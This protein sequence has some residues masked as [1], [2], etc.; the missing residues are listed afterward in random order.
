[1]TRNLHT[2][3]LK[4][5][6]GYAAETSG[7]GQFHDFDGNAVIYNGAPDSLFNWVICKD[8]IT[9]CQVIKI[10]QFL[11][12]RNWEVT[13]AVDT[14]MPGLKFFL[15]K[16]GAKL[17]SEP[18]KAFLNLAGFYVQCSD[19]DNSLE[20]LKVE[21][22]QRLEMFDQFTSKIFCHK[23][24]VVTKFLKG[25]THIKQNS[26]N[27]F[28]VKKNQEFVGT[29][30]L[31]VQGDIAGFYADGVFE[32]YRNQG[33][34]TQLVLKRIQIAK[35]MGCQSVIAPCMSASVSLYKRIGFRMMGKLPLYIS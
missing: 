33:I 1:M 3:N 21:D 6:I 2:K 27:A 29:C 28:L 35:E 24:D 22:S 11:K 4:D 13:W 19:I 7:L 10:L 17:V 30:T 8:D 23:T 9:E 14:H 31:Y 15:E 32:K 16:H 26:L 12:E 20:F 34:G 25:V 18:K 5:Y